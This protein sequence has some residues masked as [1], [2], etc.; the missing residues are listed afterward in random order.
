[1]MACIG[2]QEDGESDLRIRSWLSLSSAA[3]PLLHGFAQPVS[4]GSETYRRGERD[5]PRR[6]TW[7]EA[8][9]RLLPA[10]GSPMSRRVAPST[11][12]SRDALPPGT[13]RRGAQGHPLLGH[14]T[15]VVVAMNGRDAPCERAPAVA[16]IWSVDRRG[17]V[18]LV[19]FGKVQGR[20]RRTRVG[21]TAGKP[22]PTLLPD[23]LAA[24]PRARHT[25]SAR[26]EH[27]P[28]LGLS[29]STSRLEPVVRFRPCSVLAEQAFARSSVQAERRRPGL[30][31]AG[32]AATRSRRPV[33]IRVMKAPV[34]RRAGAVASRNS[35]ALHLAEQKNVAARYRARCK[36]GK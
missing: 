24:P 5:C 15:F 18:E 13:G 32:R 27:H 9:K 31:P 10:C 19:A 1:M 36:A 22:T 16:P 4:I 23:L 8:R 17:Q 2:S 21:G 33:P 7:C 14:R 28:A 30:S 3:K 25:R 20:G 6:S 26:R 35:R 34:G 12:T 11:V 29:G